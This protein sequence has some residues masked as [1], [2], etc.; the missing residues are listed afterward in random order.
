MAEAARQRRY[1]TSTTRRLGRSRR[2]VGAVVGLWVLLLNLVAAVALASVAQARPGLIGAE[3]GAGEIVICT[4]FGMRVV[5][6]DGHA[7]PAPAHR[8]DPVCPYCLPLMQGAVPPPASDDASH[9]GLRAAGE[10]E[11]MEAVSALWSPAR[12]NASAS[13]RGPPAV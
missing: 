13:P 4:G 7:L 11:P 1:D 9:P 2:T 10:A 3:A 8:A 12:L 6:A 5:D